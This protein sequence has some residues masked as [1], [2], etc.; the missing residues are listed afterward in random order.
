MLWSA[1]QMEWY[2]NRI[3]LAICKHLRNFL[4]THL[5]NNTNNSHASFHTVRTNEHENYMFQI[6]LYS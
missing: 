5:L 4:A 3:D 6:V 2:Q 1:R